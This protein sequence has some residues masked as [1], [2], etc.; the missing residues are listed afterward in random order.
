ML[1]PIKEPAESSNG[2]P[3]LPAPHIP[4]EALLPAAG[5]PLDADYWGCMQQV[6][7]TAS[8]ES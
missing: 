7:G 3:E 4:G 2:P 1:M 6:H 5:L 8:W